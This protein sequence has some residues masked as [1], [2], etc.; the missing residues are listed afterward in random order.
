M[1]KKVNLLHS[2]LI[3]SNW[4]QNFNAN[5]INDGFDNSRTTIPISLIQFEKDVED[6]LRQIDQIALSPNN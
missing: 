6:D 3:I 2:A 4:I 1:N 5:S